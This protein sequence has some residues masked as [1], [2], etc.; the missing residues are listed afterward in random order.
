MSKAYK[1]D[2]CGKFYSN[3][4]EITGFDIY[5]YDY[6]KRGY[7]NVDKKTVISEVCEDC[8]NDIKNYIH[9]KAFETAKKQIK[10]SIN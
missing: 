4:Y 6:A 3:C 10:G 5:P 1:C 7:P 8:Y 9:N 2:V